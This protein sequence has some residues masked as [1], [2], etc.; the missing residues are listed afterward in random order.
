M[1]I[2]IFTLFLSTSALAEGLP[3]QSLFVSQYRAG[4]DPLIGSDKTCEM[5]ERR[6]EYDIQEECKKSNSPEVCRRDITFK[7]VFERMNNQI[8]EVAKIGIIEGLPPIYN[9]EESEKVFL[10]PLSCRP[11]AVSNG[12]NVTF[13]FVFRYQYYVNSFDELSSKY[14]YGAPLEVIKK[15]IGPRNFL[16]RTNLEL[17]KTQIDELTINVPTHDKDH[18]RKV[19]C[20][21]LMEEVKETM[22]IR[23]EEI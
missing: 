10:R 2:L 9:E 6:V 23:E 1:K 20:E 15:M 18:A 17:S 4:I 11:L 16:G 5:V 19:G 21:K 7:T 22:I 8:C 3:S 12:H 13:R 14:A